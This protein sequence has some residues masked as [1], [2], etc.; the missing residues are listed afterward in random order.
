MRQVVIENPVINSPF[1]EPE[2]HF[3]FADEGI[4]DE[5]VRA[6]RRS[7]YF[8]PIAQPK[9]KGKGTGAGSADMEQALIDYLNSGMIPGGQASELEIISSKA[10]GSGIE[11]TV[12]GKLTGSGSFSGTITTTP[13]GGKTTNLQF[14]Y[15]D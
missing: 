12:S 11:H 1:D 8:I 5:I 7:Q 14:K 2:R 10:V 9:K 4:T 13:E 3:R 6:R 15:D